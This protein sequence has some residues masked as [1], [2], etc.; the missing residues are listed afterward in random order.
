MKK[1]VFCFTSPNVLSACVFA[2][3]C[4][5]FIGQASQKLVRTIETPMCYEYA[6][7]A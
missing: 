3:L 2:L 7:S 1:S 4:V 5:A 6:E